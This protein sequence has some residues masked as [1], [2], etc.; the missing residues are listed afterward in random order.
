VIVGL[1]GAAFQ[2]L[3]IYVVSAVH[4]AVHSA[5]HGVHL[6]R[7]GGPDPVALYAAPFRIL[8]VLLLVPTAWGV[9]ALPHYAR[10][11]R[12]GNPDALR[13][14]WRRDTRAGALVGL[15]LSVGAAL[16]AYPLTQVGLGATYLPAAPI[17]AVLGWM[18]L[19]V[20]LSA[21]LIALLTATDRQRRIAICVTLAGGL[22]L[23]ANLAWGGGWAQAAGASPATHLVGVA[24][25]KVVSMAVL[26][27]MY[28]LAAL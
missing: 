22:A 17:L 19:P 14:R 27:L 25:I 12:D 2:S 16:L 5:A 18:A 4:S 28:R 8:H 9:V 26:L 23:A 10:L 13:S 11:V 15:A 20:C 3:D 6:Q 24:A 21:P 1:A 7:A